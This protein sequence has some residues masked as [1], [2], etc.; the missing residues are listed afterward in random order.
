M[1]EES[2]AAKGVFILS[3]A[4]IMVK[5]ISVLYTPMLNSIL[6]VAGY[7]VYSKTTEVFLL[8]YALSSMGVQPAVAKTVA[9]Y[10]ALKN[11]KAAVRTLRVASKFYGIVGAFFG[12]LMILLAGVISNVAESPNLALGL[13]F[14]APCI[15]VTCLLSA[16][17]GFMQGKND[18]T[19]IG[20]SQIIEQLLNVVISLL[21]AFILV[22]GSIALGNAG[23]QIGTSVGALF[24]CF[25]VLYCYEKKQYKERAYR[26][27]E[28][29]KRISDK[30]ILAKIIRYSVPITISAGLQNIG[31]VVDMFNVSK[32]LIV[33]GFTSEQGDILYGLLGKYK[34]LYGVP[35]V[36]I[37]AIGT[38]VLPSLTKSLVLKQRKEAKKKIGYAFKLVLLIA[39]PSAVGLSMVSTEV[40]I[41]LFG[42]AYGADIMLFG[43]VILVLM[44]ITQTQ[45]VILQA[46]NKLYYVLI[47][48]SV[49][50]VVKIVVNY[51]LVGIPSINI[52]GVIIGNCLWHL[53]PAILN[54]KK[55]C[56]SMKMRM[57]LLKLGIKPIFASA[58]MAIVIFIL[59]QPLEFM[60]RFIPLTRWVALPVTIF[61]VSIG[62][63]IYLYIMISIGGISRRD[64]DGISPKIMRF[65]PRF[66]R[67][68]L[69]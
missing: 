23:A 12:V 25:Y 4:G 6:G 46:T 56:N 35:L 31:G 51:V 58:V 14:L 36:I 53:I 45:S 3:L 34:T 22:Q 33:A 42:D 41:F 60:Y 17:R 65:I 26:N 64:V 13:R 44:S 9:E 59:K 7:G 1:R 8:V 27:T 30:R 37:T 61:L 19:F 11:D 49:G 52:Y 39:I 47:T 68:K 21:C 10:T 15:F 54:H 48:F 62:G 67:I 38:T 55:I 43:S 2:S 32:R 40:Y 28:P 69:K 63:F 24:A 57:S 20:I 66:M 16:L 29:G 50:I 5:L 18:M